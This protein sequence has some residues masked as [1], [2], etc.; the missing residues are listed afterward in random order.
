MRFGG[1]KLITSR[2][3]IEGTYCR[4][5]SFFERRRRWFVY[6]LAVANVVL[7]ESGVGKIHFH[8]SCEGK[9]IITFLFSTSLEEK[10][11][12]CEKQKAEKKTILN[13]HAKNYFLIPDPVPFSINPF[14][15]H[16]EPAHF[17]RTSLDQAHEV[18]EKSRR[19]K[20]D[21]NY[22]HYSPHYG[23]ANV[24]KFNFYAHDR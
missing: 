5:V 18:H 12:W 9:M 8:G 6:L 2:R 14:I 21:I 13:S 23:P 16:W 17:S 19:R 24:I 3:R 11:S 4:V 1:E 15:R 20:R 10:F 7:C 22:N